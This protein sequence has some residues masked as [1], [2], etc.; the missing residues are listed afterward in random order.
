MIIYKITN[1]INN[2]IYIGQTT[3]P[4]NCRWNDHCHS[5]RK[6]NAITNAI[7]KYGKD[8]FS[9]EVLATVYKTDDLNRLEKFYIEEFNSLAPK[10]YNLKT[11]GQDHNR[12]TDESKKKMSSARI[13]TTMPIDVRKKISKTHKQRF[14]DN[15]LLSQQRSEMVKKAWTDPQYRINKSIKQKEYWSD[16][17][18]RKRHSA[19]GK[20]LVSDPEYLK[21][22]SNGVKKAQQRPE[23]KQRMEQFYKTKCKKVINDLQEIFD[24]I[25]D[26]AEAYGIQS[27]SI[28]KQIQ[29]EYKTAGKRTWKYLDDRQTVYMLIGAPAS[30]KSWVAN[31]LLDQYDYVSYDKNRKKDHLQLLANPSDKDKLYDPTFKIS[32]MIRRHSDEFNFIIVCIHESE[33][34]LRDRIASR[35]GQWTDTILK[36]N[37]QV[38]KRYEKYGNGGIIGTSNEVLEYL[39]SLNRVKDE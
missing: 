36:R 39:K 20:Q 19:I 4:L 9:I 37:E 32:T 21:K 28:T 29:G 8:N 31:Q 34:V 2:K 16:D 10:G 1:L 14:K 3:Q 33:D 17:I 24:S 26:A 13:G 7:R 6:N 11:G 12:Y 15:P 23:V 27:S 22:V 38:R 18:N 30:G 35:N 5:K 25:K